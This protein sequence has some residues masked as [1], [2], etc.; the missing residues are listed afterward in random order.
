MRSCIKF[1]D[2]NMKTKIGVAQL[3]IASAIG[4]DF[5]SPKVALLSQNLATHY[6]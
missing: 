3:M 2:E 5:P 1:L 6:S 4:K